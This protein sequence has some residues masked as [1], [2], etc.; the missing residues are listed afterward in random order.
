MPGLSRRYRCDEWGVQLK[1]IQLRSKRLKFVESRQNL[2]QSTALAIA[3]AIK[4]I[5]CMEWC[6]RLLFL[7]YC[8]RFLTHSANEN[9]YH[10]NLYL[11]SANMNHQTIYSGRCHYHGSSIQ[12]SSSQK[13]GSSKSWKACGHSWTCS[14]FPWQLRREDQYPCISLDPI[15]L[16]H[17]LQVFLLKL[18]N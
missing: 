7:I 4:C 14:N 12:E 6:K 5:V 8:L 18:M 2:P 9:L 11:G 15:L 10:S 3:E 16:G 1:R 13:T 17:Q